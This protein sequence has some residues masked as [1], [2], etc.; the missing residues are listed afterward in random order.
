MFPFFLAEKRQDF[1]LERRQ[2]ESVNIIA[3]GKH[4]KRLL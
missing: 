4:Q 2:I 3:K 1:P